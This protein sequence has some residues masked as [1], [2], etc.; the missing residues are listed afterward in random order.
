M[1][2][3]AGGAAPVARATSDSTTRS[4][5]FYERMH[6]LRGGGRTAYTRL[7]QPAAE[8]GHSEKASTGRAPRLL[9]LRSFGQRV[10]FEIDPAPTTSCTSIPFRLVNDKVVVT[11]EVNGG[12][13]A[14]SSSTPGQNT[15]GDACR[16]RSAAASCRSPTRSA[17]ASAT[18]GCGALQLG[19][20]RLAR[21]RRPEAAATCR[22]SSRTRRCAD[23]CRRSDTESFSP[24]ALGLS[25]SSTTRSTSLT[26]G[27]H[28]PPES[29]PD[30]ELP[31]WL[32]RLATVHG[33]VGTVEGTESAL[34]R[35]HRRRGHLD[36]PGDGARRWQLP[37]GL[38][39]IPLQGVWDVGLGS[40]ARSC[41]PAS[42]WRST[43]FTYERT[44]RSS[45]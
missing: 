11:G 36:Q 42:I 28:L 27:K 1:D 12:P 2:H 34:R 43:R 20:D 10:P 9:V 35:R 41:C 22:A 30:F 23:D 14:I 45:C 16:R 17:P 37:S 19:A 21:D 5:S 25:M 26:I 18:S 44:S 15:G 4:A 40:R 38:R 24:L 3:G 31:L 8:Q 32:Y 13:E 6:K 39:R 29:A 33:V 7:R